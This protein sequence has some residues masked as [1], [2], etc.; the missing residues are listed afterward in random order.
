M[1]LSICLVNWNTRE[2]L[3]RCLASIPEG[4]Q[5]IAYEILV[6]D[7]ASA[8]GS[9]EMV[10]RDFPGVH[11]IRNDDNLGF[12]R[13]NN[14][15]IA[16]SRGDYI[17]LLNSDT[18]VHPGALA[19]L[20]AALDAHP[21]AGIAGAKLLN[22]DGSLQYSCRRFPTFSAGLV[23]N[24]PLARL[25]PGHKGVQD[26]LMTDFDHASRC[27]V[28]W[29]SGAALCIRRQTLQQIGR[30]DEGYFMYCEDVDWCY[31]AHQAGWD[32]QYIPDAVI[33]HLIGRS[34]D[35]AVAAMVRAHHTSMRRFYWKHYAPKTPWLMRWVPPV[36][37]WLRLQVTLLAKRRHAP[38]PLPTEPAVPAA[39]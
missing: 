15:A 25:L 26:Y 3:R 34:S 10:A 11:L 8:D 7:N 17:L 23:R 4:A 19:C 33:T 2:D 35:K 38:T 32:V 18:V 21:E 24:S 14:Q 39:R 29:V 20:V 12:S 9:P 31:R 27:S 30:L 28:D 5:T 6:V 1:L 13:A 16:H 37:I 22:G 36:G